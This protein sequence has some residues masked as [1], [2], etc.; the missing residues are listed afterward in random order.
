MCYAFLFAGLIAR[1]PEVSRSEVEKQDEIDVITCGA[2][3]A[4]TEFL[5]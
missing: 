1:R 4:G 2:A 5:I 3:Q